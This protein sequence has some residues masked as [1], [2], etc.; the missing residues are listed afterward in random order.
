[1]WNQLYS[2]QFNP[3]Y[4]FY[5]MLQVKKCVWTMTVVDLFEKIAHFSNLCRLKIRISPKTLTGMCSYR[6]NFVRTIHIWQDK[7]MLLIKK[8]DFIPF[9]SKLCEKK[10]VCSKNAS[11]MHFYVLLRY[12]SFAKFNLFFKLLEA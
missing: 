11:N 10:L 2:T 9:V 3:S 8:F 5:F 6:F 4:R 1:M 12:N 7:C